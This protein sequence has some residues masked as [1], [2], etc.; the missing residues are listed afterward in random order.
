MGSV[1]IS[2]RGV[3]LAVVATGFCFFGIAPLYALK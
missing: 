1:S 3:A 2:H